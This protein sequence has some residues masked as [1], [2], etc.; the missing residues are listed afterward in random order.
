MVSAQGGLMRKLVMLVV[1]SAISV[2][3]LAGCSGDKNTPEACLHQTTMDL[4]K[5]NYDAVLASTC[6]EEM[7]IG[8]AWFGKAGYDITNVLNRFVDANGSSSSSS[9]QKTDLN[10]YMTSLT[11]NV[12]GTTLTYLDNARSEGYDKVLPEESGYLDARFY[13][14]IVDAVKSLSLIKIVIPNIVNADGTL[15][16]TCDNNGNNVPDE[17]D[18]TACEL[19][20]SVNINSSPTGTIACKAASYSPLTPAAITLTDSAGSPV[21][22][23]YSG[24]TISMATGT[25]PVTTGCIPVGAT[26][27]KRLLYKDAATNKWFAATTTGLCSGSDGQQWPCPVLGAN[28]DLTTSIDASIYSAVSSMSS[29]VTAT[30]SDVKTSI[31]DIQKDACTSP[32]SSVCPGACP[33]SCLSGATTYCSSTDISNYIQNN[34]H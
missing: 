8:A 16:K 26:Q 15:N 9:T 17:A 1:T 11:G 28:L 7:Q 32:C 6:A 19:I 2:L 34:L 27:Y 33:A 14:S 12:T 25:S 13:L 18:A 29:A 22:G 4:D 20:A 21:T 3:V 23:T 10:I 31:T 24:L 5:G 30:N